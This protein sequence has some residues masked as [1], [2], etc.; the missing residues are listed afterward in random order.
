MA[1]IKNILPLVFFPNSAEYASYLANGEAAGEGAAMVGV[2]AEPVANPVP[3]TLYAASNVTIEVITGNQAQAAV[4]AAVFAD[5]TSPEE[6]TAAELAFAF[7][8]DS[9]NDA[10]AST[11]DES[12]DQYA[13]QVPLAADDDD[14]LALLAAD[15]DESLNG[16]SRS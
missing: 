6:P 7:S 3:A 4:D 1:H 16:G 15:V 5:V 12:V 2:S 8:A 11:T 13:N 10:Y 14:L 9:D